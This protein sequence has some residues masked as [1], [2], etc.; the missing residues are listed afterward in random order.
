MCYVDGMFLTEKSILVT[1][2]ILT[3]AIET[4]HKAFISHFFGN[5]YFAFLSAVQ[6]TFRFPVLPTKCGHESKSNLHVL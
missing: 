3:L 6:V 1:N 4:N 2:I 5:T